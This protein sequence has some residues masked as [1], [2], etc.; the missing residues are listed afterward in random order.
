VCHRRR[1]HHHHHHHHQGKGNWA[2]V[3][4]VRRVQTGADLLAG[5]GE[6][7]TGATP[8]RQVLKVLG[9]ANVWEMHVS[10]LLYRTVAEEAK[11]A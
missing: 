9:E 1:H 8:A 7:D 2:S 4:L 10:S 6:E 3:Y 11:V 5:L